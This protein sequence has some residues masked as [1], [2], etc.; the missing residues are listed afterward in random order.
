M[1]KHHTTEKNKG[2]RVSFS[3]LDT[4]EQCPKKY[5]LRYKMKA[6]TARPDYFEFGTII[7]ATLEHLLKQLTQDRHE[8]P[9][10]VDVA[11]ELYGEAWAGAGCVDRALFDE[12]RDIITKWCE[13]FGH[14][15]RGRVLA[16]EKPFRVSIAGHQVAGIVDRVDRI[17]ERTIRV[18][19]Y[20]TSRAW[21]L[22]DD[23]HQLALYGDAMRE[24]YDAERVQIGFD[25]VRH[26][27]TVVCDLTPDMV[28]RT[29]Q[30]VD[31]LSRQLLQAESYPERLNAFCGWCDFREF[32]PT[33]ATAVQAP[34]STF[35]YAEDPAALS[36]VIAASK[37]R[38]DDLKALQRASSIQ[39]D[40]PKRPSA[41]RTRKA[42][43]A[44]AVRVLKSYGVEVPLERMSID[45]KTL[46]DL[47]R[48]L[49]KNDRA[50]ASA[51]IEAAAIV[52]N[53]TVVK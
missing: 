17:D 32:C 1:Q 35:K 8:G 31:V 22:P 44:A 45:N 19:D 10:P 50:V 26:N 11:L 53:S 6:K 7:H 29:Y 18:I 40:G 34:L 4:F 49:D 27:Q 33:Y 2:P 47:V 39:G 12:G 3:R 20:K 42:P 52:S 51:K 36:A 9:I 25:M 28:A 5:E 16:L 46:K 24:I 15:Q 14:L 41:R 21:M 13:R 30:W 23:S 43:A 48:G 37:K 38:L